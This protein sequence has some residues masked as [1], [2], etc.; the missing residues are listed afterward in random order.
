MI[1]SEFEQPGRRN[2]LKA[3]VSPPLETKMNR[4]MQQKKTLVKKLKVS[5]SS[6]H[7]NSDKRET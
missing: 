7:Q 5:T 2:S 4:R 3:P 1:K 6:G